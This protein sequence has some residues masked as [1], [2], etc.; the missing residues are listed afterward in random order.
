MPNNQLNPQQWI[1]A[2]FTGLFMAGSRTMAVTITVFTRHRFGSRY[3]T[4][5]TALS[6]FIGLQFVDIVSHVLGIANMFTG[7]FASMFMGAMGYQQPVSLFSYVTPLYVAACVYHLLA[8]RI[9]E[10]RGEV[11]W[12]YSTG[13][14]WLGKA[15]EIPFVREN[16]FLNWLFS[17]WSLY[18][19]VEPALFFLLGQVLGNVL[20]DQF[21]STWLCGASL[22]L[23]WNNKAQ[24]DEQKRKVI[25]MQDAKIEGEYLAEAM[26]GRD[27]KEIFGYAVLPVSTQQHEFFFG[28]KQPVSQP[29]QA[30]TPAIAATPDI[31]ATVAEM[32]NPATPPA[33]G[34]GNTR[35]LTS[36]QEAA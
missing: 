15:R 27:K 5:G 23:Y 16:R 4:F 28:K 19:F 31:D 36:E 26:A 8:I 33:T 18:R 20:H 24:V 3:L 6:G 2:F 7:G 35:P 14:P 17:D 11:W 32:M 21:T 34:G 9:R 22:G 12:S 10:W 30:A 1:F 29:V 25:D 13:I